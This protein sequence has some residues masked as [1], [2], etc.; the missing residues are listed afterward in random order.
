M[1]LTRDQKI[2]CDVAREH[3]YD[4]SIVLPIM[5]PNQKNKGAV[6]SV[7]AVKDGA[8]YNL[9]VVVK[10]MVGT[11]LSADKLTVVFR[12]QSNNIDEC[13]IEE[14]QRAPVILKE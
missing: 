14:I 10:K 9:R 6:L 13:V 1:F 2:A 5:S 3:G 4:P 8:R 7:A 12:R 11:L